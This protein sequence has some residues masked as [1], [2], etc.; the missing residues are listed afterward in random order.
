MKGP[1]AVLFCSDSTQKRQF[2]IIFSL[3]VA[4]KISS[5]CNQSDVI[6]C[7]CEAHGN[8]SPKLEWRRSGNVLANSTNTLIRN[9]TLGNTSSK[10]VLI[11]YQPLTDTDVLQCFSANTLGTA[12]ASQ[13]VHP[14]ARKP[15]TETREIHFS[16]THNNSFI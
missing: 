2:M 1:Q 12:S 3:S 10:S 16:D 7:V 15:G 5:S 9:E 6:T 13:R 11:I 14:A 8:P 4:P